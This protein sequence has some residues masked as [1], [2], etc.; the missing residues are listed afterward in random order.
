M[1]WTLNQARMRLF[2]YKVP[3]MKA[4]ANI[5]LYSAAAVR[6]MMWRENRSTVAERSPFLLSE[7]IEFF[8]RWYADEAK[9]VPTDAQFAADDE[10]Q[11]RLAKLVQRAEKDQSVAKADL[12]SKTELAC[13]IVQILQSAKTTS[14]PDQSTSPRRPE[15]E[16]QPHQ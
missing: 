14:V 16:S 2:R 8:Q 7:M 3:A 10:I 9:G 12:A 4:G 5:Y 6:D 15:A 11:R 1:G 13:K